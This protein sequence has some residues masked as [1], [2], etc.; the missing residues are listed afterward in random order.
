MEFEPGHARIVIITAG[1]PYHVPQELVAC[2]IPKLV[3]GHL[4]WRGQGCKEW[5]GQGALVVHVPRK[6]AVGLAVGLGVVPPEL[7][8]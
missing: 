1:G 7:G 5:D 3:L 6:Q 4:V 8:L 2:D